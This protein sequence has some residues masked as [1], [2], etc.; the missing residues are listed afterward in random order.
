[1]GPGAGIWRNNFRVQVEMDTSCP[2]VPGFP[3]ERNQLPD[4]WVPFKYEKLG[5]FCFG[6]GLL[7]HDQRD[8]QDSGTQ[9]FMREGVSFGFFGR[10][11]HADNDE[12]QSGMNLESLLNSDMLGSGGYCHEVAGDGASVPSGPPNWIQSAMDSWNAMIARE[13]KGVRDEVV[14][15]LEQCKPSVPLLIDGVGTE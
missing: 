15:C 13:E 7:G 1:M 8:C 11:L 6:C 3:L 9:W 14:V 10:W 12:F 2:L 5:N 4:L